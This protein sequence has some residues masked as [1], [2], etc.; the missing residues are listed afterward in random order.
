MA[1]ISGPSEAL[2]GQIVA[3]N[4][5]SSLYWKNAI[6]AWDWNMGDGVTMAGPIVEHAYADAGTYVVSLV[7]TDSAGRK[8][9]RASASIEILRQLLP[10]VIQFSVSLSHMDVTVEASDSYDPDGTIVSYDWDFGDGGVASGLTATHT[11]VAPGAYNI[12]LVLT[13]NDGMTNTTS[14]DVIIVDSPPTASFTYLTSGTTVTVDATGSGDDY[15]IVSYSWDWGDGT[16]GTGPVATHTY[17]SSYSP[18]QTVASAISTSDYPPP[19][20][21]VVGYVYADDGITPVFG[22]TVTVTNIR[23]GD[24]GTTTTEYDYGVYMIDLADQLFFP[25][26]WMEGDFIQVTAESGVFAGSASGPIEPGVGYLWLDVILGPTVSSYT[27]TLTVTDTI[28]Q[29]RTASESLLI[30][31]LPVAS[32]TYSISDYT[33]S[34]DASGSSAQAGIASYTWN[35][36]DGTYGFGESAIHSYTPGTFTIVLTVMDTLNQIGT[37]TAQVAFAPYA[38]AFAYVVSGLTVSVDASPSSGGSIVDYTW[39]WGDG[40]TGSGFMASHTYSVAGAYTISLVATYDNGV[41]YSISKS[42]QTE[43]PSERTVDYLWY[44]M[45]NVPLGEWYDVRWS[46]YGGEEP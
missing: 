11:Y 3:F 29:T 31:P 5:S 45:F 15:G 6:L 26:G 1:V 27:I 35:W 40:S 41:T 46:V 38:L 37:A 14:R 22:C 44:D 39:Y 10:P 23:T 24:S 43:G 33:V 21:P 28:G 17:A 2:V 25:S 9:S 34:V 13:D 20:F 19:P 18:A 4:G 7:V 42:V 32:F 8:S 12:A 16:S 30:A 36:G